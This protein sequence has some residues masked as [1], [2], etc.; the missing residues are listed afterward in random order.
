MVVQVI[1]QCLRNAN[2]LESVANAWP[3]LN[4]GDLIPA[5]GPVSNSSMVDAVV[6]RIILKQKMLVNNNVFVSFARHFEHI[7]LDLL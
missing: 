1:P 7:S 6:M 2:C 4:A 5:Q 3:T